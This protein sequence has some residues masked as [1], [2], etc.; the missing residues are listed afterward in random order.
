M[1]KI[2]YIF[3]TAIICIAAIALVFQSCNNENGVSLSDSASKIAI[4]SQYDHLDL[5]K[6]FQQMGQIHNE[7]LDTVFLEANRVLYSTATKA[8]GNM[9]F[10][11]KSLE[12]IDIDL[13]IKKGL[14]RYCKS[15]KMQ[16]VQY[17]Q[18]ER[19][20]NMRTK[21]SRVKGSSDSGLDS[22]K[23]TPDQKELFEKIISAL[24]N[25]DPNIA[26]DGLK[27]KLDK[28][29]KEAERRLTKNEASYIYSASSV[30][31]SSF[32]YWRNNVLKWAVL[33]ANYGIGNDKSIDLCRGYTKKICKTKRYKVEGRGVELSDGSWQVLEDLPELV[34]YPSSTWRDTIL[35]I[36]NKDCESAGE[37]LAIAIL[38]AKYATVVS[39]GAVTAA[40]PEVGA[41]L[42]AQVGISATGGSILAAWDI[43]TK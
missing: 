40:A 23:I 39:G 19:I 3:L 24:A 20:I 28:I 34:C 35:P 9:Q 7:G 2:K 16:N 13:I 29:N 36:I 31:F 43:L 30:G 32:Q 25:Q 21:I 10:M 41:V 33:V 15:N 6:E 27:L 37:S 18:C 42:A 5:P 38:E 14:Q 4:S 26:I 12:S 1:K 8:K 17:S 22:K 11:K